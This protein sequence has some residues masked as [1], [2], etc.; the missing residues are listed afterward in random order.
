M[1][2]HPI[3]LEGQEKEFQMLHIV[4]I[5]VVFTRRNIFDGKTHL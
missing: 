1:N 5:E 4:T 2:F 3:I